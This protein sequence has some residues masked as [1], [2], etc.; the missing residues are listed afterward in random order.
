MDG[1][2][3][4]ALKDERVSGLDTGSGD[5]AAI[6]RIALPTEAVQFRNLYLHPCTVVC[7]VTGW[8]IPSLALGARGTRDRKRDMGLR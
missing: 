8:R 3:A 5:L 7:F 2:P 4:A 1:E 6:C